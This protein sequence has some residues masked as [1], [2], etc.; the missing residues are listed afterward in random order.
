LADC[1]LGGRYDGILGVFGALEVLR[2]VKESGI[3]T[4]APL[5]AINWT[6]E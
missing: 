5:A 2:T 1:S 4:N 3:T 6:N